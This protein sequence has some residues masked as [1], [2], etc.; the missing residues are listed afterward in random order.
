MLM[1]PHAIEE[2]G[3]N[4]LLKRKEDFIFEI[5]ED[6]GS[7]KIEKHEGNILIT[8]GSNPNPQM[9][10]YPDLMNDLKNNLKDGVYIVELCV[11][12]DGVSSFSHYQQ[13]QLTNKIKIDLL[14]DDLPIVAVFHDIVKNKDE[15]VTGLPL[16]ERKR[17]LKK[18][19]R[20]TEHL[21]VIE[22]YDSPEPILEKRDSLEGIVIKKRDSPYLFDSRQ[23]WYKFRFNKEEIVKCVDYE[24]TKTGIVLI[25]EDGGR[26]NC[27]NQKKTKF[28]KEK[29]KKDGGT[30]EVE[31]SH[32]PEKT[33]TK[34]GKGKYRFPTVK[35]IV[36]MKKD[37]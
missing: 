14:K 12:D 26:I 3:F 20:E 16:M 34:K 25:T 13:R 5:K 22:I 35:H 1:K 6:G 17:I 8:H 33:K 32:H 10:K 21:K 19:V 15:D 11:Y 29:L 27:P 7:S 31:I 9:Q 4:Q 28:A 23:G 2:K 37:E 18:N 24:N 36:G 30:L